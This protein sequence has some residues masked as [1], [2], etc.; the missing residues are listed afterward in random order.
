MHA[1]FIEI[2]SRKHFV[3]SSW[4]DD[5]S[6][7]NY[8]PFFIPRCCSFSFHR[9]KSTE[10]LELLCLQYY[11]TIDC[12]KKIVYENFTSMYYEWIR[13]E[14]RGGDGGEHTKKRIKL[15]RYH[16]SL[17][18][19]T[20]GEKKEREKNCSTLNKQK[21]IIQFPSSFEAIIKWIYAPQWMSVL[22]VAVCVYTKQENKNFCIFFSCIVHRKKA[23][24]IFFYLLFNR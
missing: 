14:E 12:I 22:I 3:P 15:F 1:T 19:K 24:L 20:T 21:I 7:E 16:F 11:K 4:D 8:F 13:A 5:I 2:I 9:G 17:Q 6:H 10:C 18:L 23:S